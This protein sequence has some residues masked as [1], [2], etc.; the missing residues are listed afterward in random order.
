[1]DSGFIS[2]SA[3]GVYLLLRVVWMSWNDTSVSGM[4]TVI[5]VMYDELRLP[6]TWK[7]GATSSEDYKRRFHPTR[8][9]DGALIATFHLV[10][11]LARRGES[12]RVLID[13]GTTDRRAIYM[14]S[15]IHNVDFLSFLPCR[16]L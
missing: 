14:T 10:L 9:R 13:T 12:R 3:L 7:S 4:F 11:L 2:V 15:S 1:V 16:N 8:R 6:S 5:T